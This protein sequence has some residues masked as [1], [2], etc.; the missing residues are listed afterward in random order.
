[1]ASSWPGSQSRMIEGAGD[2]FPE[3]ATVTVLVV[4]SIP[5][6]ARIPVISLVALLVLSACSDASSVSSTSS[7]PDQSVD[8][9]VDASR[10]VTTVVAAAPDSTVAPVAT[11]APEPTGVPGLDDVDPYCAAWA[12]YSGSVQAIGVADAFGQLASLDVAALELVAA[13]SINEAVDVIS[14]NWPGELAEERSIVREELLGPFARRATKAIDALRAAGV[15][16][17]ELAELRTTWLA[18]LA[19]RDPGEPVIE[20]APLP[21]EL[22]AKLDVAAAAFDLE[23]TPFVDDPSLIV[24]SVVTPLTDADL[25]TRCPELASSGVGDAV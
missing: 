16:D 7:A 19:A 4:L 5:L 21:A 8:V 18:A 9:S 15:T 3:L 24:E 25:S 22:A 2:I 20:F 1:M 6:S 12:A 10:D 11:P 14:A 17:D 13:S 23:V